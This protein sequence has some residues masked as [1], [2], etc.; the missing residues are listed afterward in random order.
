M[1]LTLVLGFALVVACAL[2]VTLGS[3][4]R[5]SRA[6]EAKAIEE[7]FVAD[8]AAARSDRATKAMKSDR[9]QFQMRCDELQVELAQAKRLRVVP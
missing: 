4:L 1:R 3:M 8:E 5:T 2:A 9:D 7:R 6:N